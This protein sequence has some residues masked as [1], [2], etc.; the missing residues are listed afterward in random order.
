MGVNM[1]TYVGVQIAGIPG[2]IVATLGLVSPAI[3]VILLISRA[4]DRFR[5]SPVVERIFYGLRPASTALI[6]AAGI[7]VARLSLLNEDLFRQTGRISALFH[8]PLIL[9]AAV[10]FLVMKRTRL[11]PVVYIA[12][13]AVA[14]VV[15]G[16]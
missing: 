1:A 8:F 15:F 13:A 3:L 6:T 12:A 4:L 11:H 7:G 9:L 5:N 16:L 10:L 14:G 2:G